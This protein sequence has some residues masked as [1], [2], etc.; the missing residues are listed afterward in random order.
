MIIVKNATELQKVKRACE[1]AAKA[2]KLTG[3]R[4]CAGMSTRELDR[5]I[6]EFIV[7][8]GGKPSSLGYR[9]F[10]GSACISV[11]EELI[12]GIPSKKK[13][14]KD[15]DIVS[16]DIA[17]NLD[18]WH[19]DNAYTFKVGKVSEKAE[20]LLQITEECLYE[21]IKAALPGNRIGDI[22]NAVQ[23]YCENKGFY[24]V[25]KYIGHG[26]GRDFHEDPDVPNFGKAGKGPRLVPG[27]TI[28]IEP[29]INSTTEE[30]KLLSDNWTVVEANGNLSAHFEHTI[31]ITEGLPVILTK[32]N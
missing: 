3:E 31:A 24:I 12:H 29:M 23:T 19:G 6:R 25:K 10:K 26:I 7:K 21:G 9:G 17:A 28:C 30:V 22:S 1:L 13:I 20:R 27:M 2:L 15:G 32:L 18:G 4:I 8:N 5:I 14:L 16:V 11:N